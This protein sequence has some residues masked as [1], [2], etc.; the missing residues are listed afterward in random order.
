MPAKLWCLVQKPDGS[1]ELRIRKTEENYGSSWRLW[2]EIL[3]RVVHMRT[4]A[5]VEKLAKTYGVE[6]GIGVSCQ[7]A[8]RIYANRTADPI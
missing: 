4:T 1:I 8:Y 3:E 6:Y 2:R 5:G 7:S